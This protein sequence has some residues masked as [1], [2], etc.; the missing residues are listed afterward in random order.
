MIAAEQRR[1]GL[2]PRVEA[3]VTE[4]WNPITKKVKSCVTVKGKAIRVKPDN[5]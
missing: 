1:G 2:S 4:D 5:E 3:D